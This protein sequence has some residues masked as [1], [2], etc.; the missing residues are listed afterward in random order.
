MHIHVS[1]GGPGLATPSF[2]RDPIQGQVS[3]VSP[4]LV[5]R[6]FVV[7]YIAVQGIGIAFL[8]GG[9]LCC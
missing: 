8:P 4:V 9:I 7:A 2:R 1:G 5:P 6:D 3:I